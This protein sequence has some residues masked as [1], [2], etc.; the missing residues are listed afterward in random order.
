MK[1]RDRMRVAV[2]PTLRSEPELNTSK[3]KPNLELATTRSNYIPC[4]EKPKRKLQGVSLQG[5]TMYPK[6]CDEVK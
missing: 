6:P 1:R 3:E 5:K 4:K 2:R